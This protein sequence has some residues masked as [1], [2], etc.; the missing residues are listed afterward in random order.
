M[1]HTKGRRLVLDKH[2]RPDQKGFLVTN[3]LP[4]FLLQLS[5][6]AIKI[7]VHLGFGIL[8][9]CFML[10]DSTTVLWV[11]LFVALIINYNQG[12]LTEGEGSVR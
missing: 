1:L 12:I 5:F 11:C 6:P 2:T 8:A 10:R 7:K 4:Y 9:F 3:A